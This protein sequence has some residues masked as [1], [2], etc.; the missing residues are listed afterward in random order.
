ML[1]LSRN[2]A[3][4]LRTMRAGM[5]W[6]WQTF[7]EFLDSIERTPKARKFHEPGQPI[8]LPS[9]GG[10]GGASGPGDEGGPPPGPA[11]PAGGRSK[12]KLTP[13]SLGGAPPSRP[14]DRVE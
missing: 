3:V 2:E 12:I 8:P 1:A 14:I 5:P 6:D 4:P 9:L 11:V 10:R 7:P 13:G